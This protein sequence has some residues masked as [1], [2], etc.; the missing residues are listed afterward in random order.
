MG[1]LIPLRVQA[2]GQP[3]QCSACPLHPRFS[4]QRP[5]LRTHLSLT[6]MATSATPDHERRCSPWPFPSPRPSPS[7]RG[8]R[9][10][11]LRA[12]FI[13]T[14]RRSPSLG[15]QGGLA[16]RSVARHPRVP[17]L[18]R[19]GSGYGPGVHRGPARVPG[20]SAPSDTLLGGGR[21]RARPA[22][23]SEPLAQDRPPAPARYAQGRLRAGGAAGSPR[24][25]PQAAGMRD[26]ALLSPPAGYAA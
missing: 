10:S 15:S 9:W 12:T 21:A 7:G 18:D 4:P 2:R 19:G 14:S 6:A 11:A 13:V 24:A 8:G 20:R 5:G 22:P 26:R 17:A 1:E 25:L 3:T 23:A 16:F